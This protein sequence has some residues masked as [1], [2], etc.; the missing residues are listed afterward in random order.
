[1]KNSGKKFEEA[2]RKSIGDKIFFYRFRDGTSSWGG[3][4]STRFQQT[5]ICDCEIFD[6]EKLFLLELKSVIGKS[7]P[8][9]N[10]KEHQLREL[11]EASKYKNIIAGFLIEFSSV[12]RVFYIDANKLKEYIDSGERKSIPLSQLVECG[13]ELDV[14]KLRVNIRLDIDKF[15]REAK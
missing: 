5:N 7:L 4:D 3:N 6:G 13:I 9:T 11:V 2:F 14:T 1:M 12:N 10:I 8:F 15:I